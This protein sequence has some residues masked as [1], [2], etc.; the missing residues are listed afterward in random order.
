[1]ARQL[2]EVLQDACQK[3]AESGIE[4]GR[5]DARILIA[6]VLNDDASSLVTK[7]ELTISE[8]HLSV[9]NEL[10]SRRQ[11]HEPVSRILGEREFW[12]LP[13]QIDANTLDPRPDTE[14]VV[15]VALK[16]AAEQ[17]RPP[18]LILDAGTG[19]GCI[20]LSLLSEWTS[21]VGVGL[22]FSPQALQ[23]A[24]KN[25]ELLGLSDRARF[26]VSDWLS[27][28][29]G[30]F[31]FIVSN[32]PYIRSGEG[33]GLPSDV[34]DFDPALALFA[35]EDG[36]AAYRVLI[37]ESRDRIACGGVFVVEV[38]YD[39]STPVCELLEQSG[40]REIT[41]HKDLSGQDRCISAKVP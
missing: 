5:L 20:L 18:K 30:N 23:V 37:P 16:I 13:F 35:G 8:D 40:Y 34:R 41:P 10:I 11:N 15:E 14:T 24:G 33:R 19:S 4:S 6:H 38:G 9:F 17:G 28:F 21:T 1:M 36:L 26:V 2:Q 7:G 3:L 25:A 29:Q 31:D 39:Q 22:D 12:S 27:A 32:P